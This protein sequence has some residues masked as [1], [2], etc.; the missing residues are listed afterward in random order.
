M[1]VCTILTKE[2]LEEI[3]TAYHILSDKLPLLPEP[4][5]FVHEPPAGYAGVYLH[6]LRAGMRFPPHDFIGAVLAHYKVHLIQVTPNGFR[7][8]MCFLLICKF[9]DIPST[10][11]LFRHF[12]AAS[13]S[14]D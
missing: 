12:Y 2:N 13:P 6:H 3:T 9:L 11:D 14:G 10:V 7:K 1:A 8:M 5:Q 4:D